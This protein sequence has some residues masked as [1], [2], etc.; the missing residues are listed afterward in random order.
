MTSIM[1]NFY[2]NLK[3]IYNSEKTNIEK[4]RL[5]VKTINEF[6]YT[7][8]DELGEVVVFNENYKYF[9]EFHKFWHLNYKEILLKYCMM[10]F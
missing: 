6:L 8:Y 1:D 9:S 4:S 3:R 10:Y 7:T 2:N 5:A